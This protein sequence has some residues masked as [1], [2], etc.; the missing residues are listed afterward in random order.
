MK[1]YLIAAIVTAPALVLSSQLTL[2]ADMPVKAPPPPPPPPSWTGFYIGADVG[3]A[4]LDQSVAWHPLPSPA[5][6][7][8]NT[9]I[10]RENPSGAIGGVYVGY[11]YQFAP[12]VLVGIEGD[13]SGTSVKGHFNQT[14]TLAG[15]TTLAPGSNLS[16][17]TSLDW[18]ASVRGRLG[19]LPTPQL[20]VYVTGGGAWG[21]FKYSANAFNGVAT[22][23][24]S[25]NA[26]VS[27]NNTQSGWVAGGGIEWMMTYNWLLRGEALVYGFNNGPNLIGT[28]VNFPAF[29]SNYV[30]GKADVISARAG[31]AYKF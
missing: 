11:N 28:S 27:V 2:A 24:G 22:G 10:D 3:F 29:P 15:T 9:I 19:F 26:P 31:V 6:F 4:S 16:M 13:F 20:L 21:D 25:Y 17:N 7:G 8:A 1:R 14:L 23:I 18:L 30:W 12:N 5:A